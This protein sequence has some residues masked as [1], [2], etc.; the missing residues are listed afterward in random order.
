MATFTLRN[1]KRYRAT[2]RLIGL[3]QFAG[4]D[5]VQ[6]KFTDVGFNNVKVTGSGAI[7]EAEGTWTKPDVT[8]E[9]DA[10]V[11]EVVQLA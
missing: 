10:H 7:R 5:I 11:I 9:I 6:G 3:E 8:G 2:L 1:G 4:N